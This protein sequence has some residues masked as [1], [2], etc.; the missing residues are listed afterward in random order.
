VLTLCAAAKL[1]VPM[2]KG[3]GENYSR[4]SRNGPKNVFA[5]V[6]PDWQLQANHMAASAA[7]QVGAP[8]CSNVP[9]PREVFRAKARHPSIF[10]AEWNA[11]F[12][13]LLL[14]DCPPHRCS[15]VVLMPS[16]H[17]SSPNCVI[18]RLVRHVYAL[19]FTRSAQHMGMTRVKQFT[20]SRSQQ[21]T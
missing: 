5:R 18:A 4:C 20:C 3:A 17:A 9:L 16:T 21:N 7:V 6:R 14:C 8:T 11:F 10:V 2:S 1:H 13:A 19:C 12:A 15:I